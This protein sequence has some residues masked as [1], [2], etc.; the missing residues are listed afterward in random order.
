MPK[1]AP[2]PPPPP[3]LDKMFLDFMLMRGDFSWVYWL[4]IFGYCF[5]AARFRKEASP[6]MK[7]VHAY[8][9][10]VLNNFG[11]SMA[12]GWVCGM[13]MSICVN[14]SLP[15]AMLIAWTITSLVP[16]VF[17][18]LKSQPVRMVFVMLWEFMRCHVVI[19]CA[20][21]GGQWLMGQTI[22]N[23]GYPVPVV[24]PLLCGVLGGCGG[25]FQPLSQGLDPIAGGLNWRIMSAIIGSVV[26]Q[27]GLRDPYTK[28]Y[29]SDD[30]V[31]ASVLLFF[32][33]GPL[34]GID[35]SACA[36]PP[37]PLESPDPSGCPFAPASAS[38]SLCV[39]VASCCDQCSAPTRIRPRRHPPRRQ[40]R[41]RIE[42]RYLEHAG[43]DARGRQRC[44]V[45]AV[46]GSSRCTRAPRA[47]AQMK[48]DG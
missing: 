4:A 1:A 9:L 17:D 5:N 20:G 43:R 33:M 25:G 36:P 45:C 10:L 30:W 27:L 15:I 2:V 44:H 32:V 40:A 12:T 39:C 24:A 42:Q 8:V 31:K 21:Q 14:E 3:G 7:F 23:L 37:P 18:I 38:L 22:K 48:I 28:D 16:P 26:L 19:I 34:L 13:P 11:G 6:A 47:K 35:K 29:V 46:R 41:R